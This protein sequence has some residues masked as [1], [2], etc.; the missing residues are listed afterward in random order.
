M[1]EHSLANSGGASPS[2]RITLI[3]LQGLGQWGSGGE[4]GAVVRCAKGSIG[5]KGGQAA[6][7]YSHSRVSEKH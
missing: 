3:L 1:S 5:N 6:R 2:Y 7:P 4:A